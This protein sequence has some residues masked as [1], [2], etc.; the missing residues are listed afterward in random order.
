M[1]RIQATRGPASATETIRC[2]FG[3]SEPQFP[4]LRPLR[5]APAR[6]SGFHWKSLKQFV[7]AN[8][9]VPS[10][11]FAP[12]TARAVIQPLTFFT[13]GFGIVAPADV[14]ASMRVEAATA[15]RGA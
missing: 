8:A 2:P 13:A 12:S 7:G 14:D 3:P 5:S 10:A 9:C 6:V 4:D 1:L 11:T 15:R